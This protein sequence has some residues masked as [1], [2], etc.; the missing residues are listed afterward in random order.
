MDFKLN[1]DICK[2]FDLKFYVVSI[3][4]FRYTMKEKMKK[5]SL[6]S[7]FKKKLDLLNWKPKNTSEE[8]VLLSVT[9][10][11][12]KCESFYGELCKLDR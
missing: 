1:I 12:L 2:I 10:N 7:T 4:I 6:F 8:P 3:Y 11:V 5:S 9:N